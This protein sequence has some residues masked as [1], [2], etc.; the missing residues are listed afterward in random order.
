MIAK[1]KNFLII[2]SAPSGGGKSTI[3]SE[4]R[5]LNS[6]VDYSVSYTTRAPR[7]TEQNGI[8][9]HFVDEAEFCRRQDEG[10]FLEHA[11]VFGKWYGTSISYIQSRL[12]ARKHVIM[13]ID[14]QGAALIGETSIPYVKIFIIPPS[15]DVLRE[16]LINRGTDSRDEINKRLNIAR[17][18]LKYIPSYQY[19]VIND[20]LAQAVQE[21]LAIIKAEENR[22]NRYHNPVSEFLGE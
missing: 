11:N 2:L 9:Y 5:K 13:D 19:L 8:H 10:D 1:S 12:D 22:V 18:E 3:L 21:V 16:R 4:V 20:D 7:G 15:M 14:V 6:E 17:N